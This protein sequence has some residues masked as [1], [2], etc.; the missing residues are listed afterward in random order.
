MKRTGFICFLLLS[1]SQ[2]AFA[3]SCGDSVKSL[4][5]PHTF[6][7]NSS[8]LKR[9]HTYLWDN[10]VIR[11][12]VSG[13][14]LRYSLSA[15]HDV[16]DNT[17]RHAHARIR[18]F[19]SKDGLRWKDQG[20]V[21][22]ES[23]TWSGHT[24]QDQSGQFHLLHTKSEF[25]E[26]GDIHQRI[27][28][29]SSSDG[30]HFSDSRTL[31]DP[32]DPTFRSQLERQGY[33]VGPSD[34]LISA[35]RDPHMF[36]DTLY[37]ATKKKRSD[38][39]VV[40]A[41]GRLKFEGA[42]F[43]R[44]PQ[45]LAPIELPLEKAITELEVPN[46]RRLPDGRF[47]LSV[48]LTDRASPQATT[49][50]VQSWIR[51]FVADSL[52]GPWRVAQGPSLDAHGNLYTPSDRVYGFNLLTGTPPSEVRGAGFFRTGGQAPHALTPLVDIHID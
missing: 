13:H 36:E 39:R 51:L 4:I 28:I 46:V 34:G 20:L 44:A 8:I 38:G 48:N 47:L 49:E 26:G 41:I 23:L 6:F 21:V 43:G 16:G 24:I 31:V 35:W 10:W 18:V 7:S 17:A 3:V 2:Q 11:D 1:C 45:I 5:R 14:Y 50:G 42:D 32:W 25:V 40:I 27:A 22:D 33:H 19:S 29:A 12:K 15:S 9:D 52:D 30:I 37:F